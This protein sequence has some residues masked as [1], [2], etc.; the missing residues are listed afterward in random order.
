MNEIERA[1][2][3]AYDSVTLDGT[4]FSKWCQSIAWVTPI[5]VPMEIFL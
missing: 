5:K 3:T 2:G 4:Q 1:N